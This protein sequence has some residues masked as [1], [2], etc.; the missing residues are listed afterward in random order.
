MARSSFDLEGIE[1]ELKLSGERKLGLHQ[2]R[3]FN[4]YKTSR[5]LLFVVI[6]III[7]TLLFMNN[8][9]WVVLLIFSIVFLSL[10]ENFKKVYVTERALDQFRSTQRKKFAKQNNFEYEPVVEYKSTLF[11]VDNNNFATDYVFGEYAGVSF[12]NA[13]IFKKYGKVKGKG[14]V[15]VSSM[16][17]TAVMLDAVVQNIQLYLKSN[18]ISY[19]LEETVIRNTKVFKIT[20]Q[21]DKQYVCRVPKDYEVD[22][23]YIFTPELLELILEFKPVN[24]EFNEQLA[25]LYKDGITATKNDYKELMK[26]VDELGSEIVENTRRYKIEHKI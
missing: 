23:L 6:T 7:L 18:L 13:D 12:W 25:V 1:G 17:A 11:S 26:L 5:P 2:A 20:Q 9:Y 19:P 8:P 15:L 14:A 24:V 4:L 3:L 21:F 16:S 22:T 10:M